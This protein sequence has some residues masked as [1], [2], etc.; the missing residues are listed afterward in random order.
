MQ[1]KREHL[2]LKDIL[3]LFVY[4]LERNSKIYLPKIVSL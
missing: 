2:Q 1:R 4:P 3:A